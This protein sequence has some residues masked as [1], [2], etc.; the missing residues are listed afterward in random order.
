MHKHEE[1]ITAPDHSYT[2]TVGGN[3]DGTNT[4][5]PI[6]YSNYTQA[7]ENNVAVKLENMGP[8]AVKNPWIII[9][10]K[11]DWRTLNAIISAIITDA[12]DDAE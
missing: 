5:D 3:M 12:M 7:W 1:N 11:R 10:N 4:R 9:N 8:E 2:I 6:G